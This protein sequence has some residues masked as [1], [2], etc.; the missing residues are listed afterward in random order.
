M[1]T[2]SYDMATTISEVKIYYA[3]HASSNSGAKLEYK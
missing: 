1:N 3:F 2:Q